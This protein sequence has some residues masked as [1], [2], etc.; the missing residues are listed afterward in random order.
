MSLISALQV[1]SNSM[2]AAQIGLQVVGNNVA[3]SATP[4]YLRQEVV[5]T[6]APGYRKGGLILGL[7]VDVQAVIQK[8]DGFL[9]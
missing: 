8:S 9:E 7:G 6:P 3:N 5:L 1:A 4:D 2:Q